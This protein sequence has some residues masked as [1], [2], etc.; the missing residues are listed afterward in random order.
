MKT[1]YTDENNVVLDEN[2]AERKPCINKESKSNELTIKLYS[3]HNINMKFLVVVIKPSIYQF[4]CHMK[5]F[6]IVRFK[7]PVAYYTDS[8]INIFLWILLI[9]PELNFH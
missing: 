3:C 4:Y 2:S 5:Y 1:V 8:M 9:A 7:Y 6:F